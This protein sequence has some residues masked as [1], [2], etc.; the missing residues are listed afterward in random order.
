MDI[1]TNNFST[2]GDARSTQNI[3]IKFMACFLF[4]TK[5]VSHAPS[6]KLFFYLS[7]LFDNDDDGYFG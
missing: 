1:K 7:L 6:Q 5:K 2:N 4:S 3:Q